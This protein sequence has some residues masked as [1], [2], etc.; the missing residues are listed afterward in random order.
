MFKNSHLSATALLSLLLTSSVLLLACS[1]DGG[2]KAEN[3]PKL[4][5][6]GLE[7]ETEDEC[8]SGY[9]GEDI[10]NP[11]ERQCTHTCESDADCEPGV[12]ACGSDSTGQRICSSGCTFEEDY[13]AAYDGIRSNENAYRNDFLCLDGAPRA[14]DGLPEELCSPF[15]GCPDDKY[16]V[17]GQGCEGPKKAAGEP[18]D[19]GDWCESGRCSEVLG[20]CEVPFGAACTAEN[21][22][23]CLQIGAQTFCTDTC[24]YQD[25]GACGNAPSGSAYCGWY[26]DICIPSCDFCS[27][28]STASCGGT[29]YWGPYG[30]D[31]RATEQSASTCYVDGRV[32]DSM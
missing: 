29:T 31:G 14:C 25:V 1:S 9:C 20:V 26:S 13:E 30:S 19:N 28:D 4:T 18:C 23:N 16:C 32:G 2:S 11:G 10:W 7:C 8:E 12:S 27:A 3:Q 24:D 17:V 15:C 22:E 21:C 6:T 5:E